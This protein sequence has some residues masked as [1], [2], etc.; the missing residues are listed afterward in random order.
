MRLLLLLFLALLATSWPLPVEAQA[1]FIILARHAEKAAPD[2]DAGLAAQGEQRARDLAAAVAG[3]R[4]SAVITTQYRRTVLIAAPAAGAARLQPLVIPATG[5]MKADAAA[6][7]RALDSLPPGSAALVVGHSNTLGP[8][9]ATLGGPPI[10]DLCDT[11]FSTLLIL[12]RDGAGGVSL[13][14][15]RYGA[16]ESPEASRCSPSQ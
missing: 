1:G 8:I 13:L 15:S 3:V 11:E 10:P 6:V 2:G 7:A 9:I 12:Q 5:N 14:R 16:A 4:L